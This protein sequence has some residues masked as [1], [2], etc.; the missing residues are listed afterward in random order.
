M[1]ELA[2]F[3]GAGGGLL[4]SSL[5]GWTTVGA[6]EI[7]KY[8]RDVLLQRQRDGLLDDFPVWDDVCT[9]DGKPWRGAVDVLSGGFPCQDISAA[10]KGAGLAGARSG[11]WK[12]YARIIDE[13]RPKFVFAENSPL[14]RTRGLGTILKDLNELG[15][16]ARWG[17]L[18]AWHIGANHRRN[19]MW[20]LGHS[21]S[22]GEERPMAYPESV[23]RRERNPH[24]RR[25][26]ES[27]TEGPE[28]LRGMCKGLAHPDSER[29]EGRHGE[30]TSRTWVEERPITGR[31]KP[32]EFEPN[33]GRVANGVA[34]RV[35]RLKAI[36][37]GQ[38]PS[39][40]ATAFRILSRGL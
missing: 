39:V 27:V 20:V 29:L 1:D 19:R 35:D 28:G 32:W 6:V 17:V 5:L 14:L 10:G 37:N 7:E 16:D 38:V 33:V 15:Y 18:G 25:S 40:A 26:G 8:P 9:F 21:N 36:G 11:L 12:E 3:A 24:N 13:V 31:S 2:L 23:R 34:S 30:N 22:D 4:G